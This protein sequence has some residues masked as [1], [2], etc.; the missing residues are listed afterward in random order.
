VYTAP[1]SAG[2][3]TIRLSSG[4]AYGSGTLHV[5]TKADSL[6]VTDAESGTALTSAVLE[7]GETLS[8]KVAAK[9]LLR[10]VYMNAENVMYS[11]S[12]SIGT[13]TRT[14]SSRQRAR[15]GP[16]AR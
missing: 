1:A 10:D 12:G 16:R 9:Y 14:A 7:Q 5:I 8:L 6:S 3:D 4:S 15:R 11:V 13:I 2:T